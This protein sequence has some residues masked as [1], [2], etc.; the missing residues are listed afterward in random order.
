LAQLLFDSP[1]TGTGFAAVTGV[2]KLLAPTTTN[3]NATIRLMAMNAFWLL[4]ITKSHSVTLIRI[5]CKKDPF[6][7]IFWDK[8]PIRTNKAMLMNLKTVIFYI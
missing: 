3:A 4:F 2:A 8:C 7:A 1:G 5:L 6:F